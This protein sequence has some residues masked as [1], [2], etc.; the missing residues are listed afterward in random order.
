MVFK[1]FFDAIDATDDLEHENFEKCKNSTFPLKK[2]IRMHF[3]K[4]MSADIDLATNGLCWP[5][6]PMLAS[7]AFT[8]F[9]WPFWP[10]WTLLDFSGLC[11][12]LLTFLAFF[13]TLLDFAGLFAS[14]CRPLLEFAGLCWPLLE[15]AGLCW[16]FANTAPDFCFIFFVVYEWAKEARVLHYI[17]LLRLA[18]DKRSGLM[19]PFIN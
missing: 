11:W 10:I 15:F 6:W 7:L 19:V 13:R 3:L 5:I 9:W 8:D 4:I 16:P 14:L 18:K 12:S 2:L 17:R 1:C